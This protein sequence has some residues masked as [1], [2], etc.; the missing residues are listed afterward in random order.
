MVKVENYVEEINLDHSLQPEAHSEKKSTLHRE[1]E[2]WWS[3]NDYCNRN[4]SFV[5][6]NLLKD[7]SFGLFSLKIC[8]P[9]LGLEDFKKKKVMGAPCAGCN[10]CK[11]GNHLV[12]VVFC[13]AGCCWKGCL[14]IQFQ[15]THCRYLWPLRRSI[16]A[17]KKLWAFRMIKIALW[18]TALEAFLMLR[19]RST[20][21]QTGLE[22]MLPAQKQMPV[23][24]RHLCSKRDESPPA[25][26]WSTW[27]TK[28]LQQ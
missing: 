10:H 27:S 26:H 8:F 9:C 2:S 25:H 7:P 15:S 11:L 28:N 22:L 13:L 16:S 21:W 5:K 19:L 4:T 17:V 20:A 23:D 3:L 24:L 14:W 12:H 6:K 18:F 1:L